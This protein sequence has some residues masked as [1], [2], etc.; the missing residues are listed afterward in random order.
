MLFM[1]IVNG[2]QVSEEHNPLSRGQ[3]QDQ[4]VARRSST[5]PH[6]SWRYTMNVTEA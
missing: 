2:D 6:T 4:P 1:K 5:H 3:D